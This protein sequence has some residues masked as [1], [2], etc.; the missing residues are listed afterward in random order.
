TAPG[1]ACTVRGPVR[2]TSVPS[3]SK[4][5]PRT[6]SRRTAPYHQIVALLDAQVRDRGTALDLPQQTDERRSRGPRLRWTYGD[7]RRRLHRVDLL[8]RHRQAQQQL[9]VRDPVAEAG[10]RALQAHRLGVAQRVDLRQREHAVGDPGI[11]RRGELPVVAQEVTDG[12][13][14]DVEPALG[15][16]HVT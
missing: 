7:R 4:T 11:G 14:G 12:L 6:R 16:D 9:L 5:K 2:W 10:A 13:V 3:M 8:R 15:V 1:I